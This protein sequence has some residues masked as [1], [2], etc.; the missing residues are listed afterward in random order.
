M[1]KIYIRFKIP[2]GVGGLSV[3]GSRKSMKTFRTPFFGYFG[4]FSY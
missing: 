1:R 3:K 2:L 4:Y